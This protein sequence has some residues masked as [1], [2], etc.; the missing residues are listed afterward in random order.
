MTVEK[1]YPEKEMPMNADNLLLA[2]MIQ[3]HGNY[4]EEKLQKRRSWIEKNGTILSDAD[5]EDAAARAKKR[6]FEKPAEFFVCRSGPC[7]ECSSR[8]E[9]EE[10]RRIFEKRVPNCAFSFTECHG[11]CKHAPAATFRIGERA[12]QFTGMTGI[13]DWTDVIN[14]VAERIKE[15]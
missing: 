2:F 11:P 7:R 13:A 3:F 10:I 9:R 4:P 8:A 6:Y 5:Y 15:K 12:E 14:E 1:T